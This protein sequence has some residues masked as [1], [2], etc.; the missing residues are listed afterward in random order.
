MH[1]NKYP[2][3]KYAVLY[4]GSRPEFV[5]KDNYINHKITDEK[6]TSFVNQNKFDAYYN[7][8]GVGVGGRVGFIPK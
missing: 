6:F 5:E 8:D 3:K 7:W 2:S 1:R 4:I